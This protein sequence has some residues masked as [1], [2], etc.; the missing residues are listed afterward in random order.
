[1][2]TASPHITLAW[3][4]GAAPVVAGREG[5]EFLEILKRSEGSF[6]D[7]QS[8]RHFVSRDGRFEAFS[9]IDAPTFQGV[10]EVKIEQS[11]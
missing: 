1:M 3:V 11:S 8:I 6:V 7:A 4:E 10:V 9:A 2:T 5:R